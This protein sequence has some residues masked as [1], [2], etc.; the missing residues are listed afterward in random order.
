MDITFVDP[1]KQRK[2]TYDHVLKIEVYPD[3]MQIYT[4]DDC[5]KQHYTIS[6]NLSDFEY[7]EMRKE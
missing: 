1:E 4:W 2:W 5:T 7:I 6:E 3:R